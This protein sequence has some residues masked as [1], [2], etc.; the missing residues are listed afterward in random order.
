MG[1]GVTRA[2]AATSDDDEGFTAT[3]N[4]DDEE[5]FADTEEDFDSDS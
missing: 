1:S 3:E 5:G 2:A 4:N